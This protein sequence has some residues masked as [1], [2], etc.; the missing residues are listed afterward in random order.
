MQD[1]KTE[2]NEIT[3]FRIFEIG[4]IDKREEEKQTDYLIFDIEIDEEKNTF[5]A[6]HTPLNEE[7]EESNKIAFKFIDIDAD[8]SLDTHLQELHEICIESILN[9][10]FYE[11]SE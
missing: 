8:F 1:I 7:E 5:K 10:E 2:F 9:S 6:T 4:V 3:E 11:L